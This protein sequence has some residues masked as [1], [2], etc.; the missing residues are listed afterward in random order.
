MCY[1]DVHEKYHGPHGLVAGTTGSG[2]SETLQT[3]MLSLA[4]NFSPD[5]ISFF[6]I[7][8]KGGGMANLF[9]DLPHHMGT[10]TCAEPW[11]PLRVRISAVSGCLMSTM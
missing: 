10:I 6:I 3:Y 5:D 11:F 2:K 4:L 8:Y 1:L 7:D 9:C